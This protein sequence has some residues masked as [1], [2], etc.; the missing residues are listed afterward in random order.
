MKSIVLED[1]TEYY[2]L[3]SVADFEMTES[4]IV[5]N[6]T[7][8][9]IHL[10][11]SMT[12]PEAN[13]GFAL[14]PGEDALVHRSDVPTW[15]RGTPLGKV[16]VQPLTSTITPFTGIELPQDLYT[17]KRE[18]FRR[19][20][21]DVGQ[22]GFFEGREYRAFTEFD[23]S[24]NDKRVYRVDVNLNTILFGVELIIDNGGARLLTV[25]D[26]TPSGIPEPTESVTIIPKNRMSVAPVV[27]N[28]NNITLIGSDLTG[29][30]IIDIVRLST[31]GSSSKQ[32]SVGGQVADERGVAV[33]TYYYV[34]ENTS[35]GPL[36]GTFKLF[37]EER[38]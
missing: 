10:Q 4:L 1:P 37:W 11:S 36:T 13:S 22:T 2:N 25:R 9:Q 8:S 5:S 12:K 35:N 38:P 21:V 27:P 31:T 6:R 34:L 26:G 28:Q 23:I 32:A 19:I 33:G 17:S 18:G 30:N 3:Y 16:I 24:S 7:S 15:I 29:G 20:R 14:W